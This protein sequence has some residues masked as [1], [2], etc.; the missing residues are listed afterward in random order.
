MVEKWQVDGEGMGWR[1]TVSIIVARCGRSA[2]SPS[3]HGSG[4]NPFRERW[5]AGCTTQQLA[6][7]LGQN[8][9]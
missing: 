1:R 3:G 2:H 5:L 9:H 7:Q 8:L 4:C 6:Q